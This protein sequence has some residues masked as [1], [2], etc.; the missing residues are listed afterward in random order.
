MFP[1][2]AVGVFA[3]AQSERIEEIINQLKSRDESIRKNAAYKLKEA[4]P[5]AKQA[6]PALT[7][8]LNDENEVVRKTAKEALTK[9]GARTKRTD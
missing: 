3:Q 5:E 2:L 7:D 1:L 4:G 8:L 6:A 9:I